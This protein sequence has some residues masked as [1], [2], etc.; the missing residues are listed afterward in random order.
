MLQRNTW[1]FLLAPTVV[2][3]LFGIGDVA[4]GT[5]ADPAIVEGLSG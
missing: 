1:K 5:D 4:R 3:V 2:I